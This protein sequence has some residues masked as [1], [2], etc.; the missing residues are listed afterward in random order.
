MLLE[1]T[2]SS[3]RR[4][5]ILYRSDIQISTS[6]TTLL[7]GL[8]PSKTG[9]WSSFQIPEFSRICILMLCRNFVW[10][11][12]IGFV[13]WTNLGQQMIGQGCRCGGFYVSEFTLNFCLG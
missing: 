11:A 1:L 7:C 9:L 4:L 10:L 5:N 8:N 6:A 12:V 13:L 2:F 3:I